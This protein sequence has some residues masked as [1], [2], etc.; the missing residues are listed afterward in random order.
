MRFKK[1]PIVIE[2]VKYLGPFSIDEMVEAWGNEFSV[3]YHLG[4]YGILKILTLEGFH[5]ASIGDWIIKG[6]AGEFY[7][8][9]PAIF[10]KTYELAEPVVSTCPWEN[11]TTDGARL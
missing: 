1:R 4:N 5:Y 7:P 9:K 3:K 10:E 11:K 6:I 8:C 2:A